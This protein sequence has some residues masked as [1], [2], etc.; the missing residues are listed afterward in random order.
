MICIS[1]ATILTPSKQISNAI[2]VVDGGRIA[3]L[4]DK[5]RIIASSPTAHEIDG[6]GGFLVPGFIDLQINGAFGYD[7]TWEPENIWEVA[8]AL[9]KYGVTSFLP[10]IV[11]SPAQ[12]IR[13]A[14]DVLMNGKPT[15]FRG[16]NPIGLHLEGPY[17]NR[18]KS[19]AHNPMHIR[20]PEGSAHASWEPSRGIRMVTLAPEIPGALDLVSDLTARGIVVSMGHSKASI[21][22]AVK[23][24]DAGARY[25][26]HLFNAMAPLDHREPGLVGALLQ[27]ERVKVGL[28]VDGIHVDPAVVGLVWRLVGEGRLNL[29]SDAMEA[30]GKQPGNYRVHEFDVVVDGTSARLADGTLA[31]SVLSLDCALRNLIKITGCELSRAVKTVTTTPADLL[32]VPDV[33]GRLEIGSAADV[34]LLSPEYEVIFTMAAGEIVYL[35]GTKIKSHNHRNNHKLS[36]ESKHKDYEGGIDAVKTA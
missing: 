34:V 2:L 12:K 4:H 3:G 13:L 21:G 8:K 30:L 26:T 19:G 33:K 29:V 11:S 18:V 1:N 25:G 10:T 32:G 27:D 7:F 5:E 15:G 28:I 9:P 23:G 6:Q 31:G 16:A 24:I 14:Q 17:L 36:A 35:D 22:Q 20:E